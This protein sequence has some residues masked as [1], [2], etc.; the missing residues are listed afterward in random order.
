[1][2]TLHLPISFL[3]CCCCVALGA[4][5]FLE[6]AHA[7]SGGKADRFI[8]LGAMAVKER[9]ISETSKSNFFRSQLIGANLPSGNLTVCY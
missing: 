9:E 5:V 8:D 3:K 4:V 1:M 6:K 2:N 7:H